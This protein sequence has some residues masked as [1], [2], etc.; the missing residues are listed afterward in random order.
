MPQKWLGV[1]NT[2]MSEDMILDRTSV[3]SSL[4]TQGPDIPQELHA[5]QAPMV[6]RATSTTFT[7]WPASVAPWTNLSAMALDAPLMC[8]L[9][10]MTVISMDPD[11]AS[12]E[13]YLFGGGDGTEVPLG[14]PGAGVAIESTAPAHPLTHFST[15]GLAPPTLPPMTASPG[16]TSAPGQ[17]FLMSDSLRPIPL[18]SWVQNGL[19]VFPEKSWDSRKV[20][21]CMGMVPQ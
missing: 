6:R 9:P 1:T 21:T 8:G 19:M 5:L 7:V 11:L 13:V 18:P 10:S 20:K 16:P 17:T 14:P 12:G 2:I 4:W 15:S 3:M